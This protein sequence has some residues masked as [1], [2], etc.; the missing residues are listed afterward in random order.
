M[1]RRRVRVLPTAVLVASF[2]QPSVSIDVQT[3]ERGVDPSGEE[4]VFE[5][6]VQELKP[7]LED[8][9]QCMVHCSKY[10]VPDIGMWNWDTGDKPGIGQC[11]ANVEET[12]KAE[13]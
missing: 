1:V 4:K 5:N 9:W 8:V 11:Q 10:T 2:F 7:G 6:Q 13:T 3:T 12:D